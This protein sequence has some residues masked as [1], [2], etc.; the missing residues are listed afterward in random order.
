MY[1][2]LTN[3]SLKYENTKSSSAKADCSGL[4]SSVPKTSTP[5]RTCMP[6]IVSLS[7]ANTLYVLQQCKMF[8]I[9]H[10]VIGT[11]SFSK[12]F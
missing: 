2:S 5:S 9:I 7:L 12:M 8:A 4:C 6:T 10:N 3:A 1:N 11:A